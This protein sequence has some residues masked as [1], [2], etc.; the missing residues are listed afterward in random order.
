MQSSDDVY[1]CAPHFYVFFLARM[2]ISVDYTQKYL[3]MSRL[4]R[5]AQ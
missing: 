1:Y 4:S 2:Q 3:F 5:C